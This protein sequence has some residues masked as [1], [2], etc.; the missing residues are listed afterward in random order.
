MKIKM[1]AQVFRYLWSGPN[2]SLFE[3]QSGGVRISQ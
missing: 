3:K 2:Q 1:T